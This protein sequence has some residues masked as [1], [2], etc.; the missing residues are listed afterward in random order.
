MVLC[1]NFSHSRIFLPE[2]KLSRQEAPHSVGVIFFGNA[3]LFRTSYCGVLALIV[4]SRRRFS[5]RSRSSHD[6]ETHTETH[7]STETHTQRRHT[8]NTHIQRRAH[9]HTLKD[10]HTY[11]QRHTDRDTH[12]I[13]GWRYP[14]EHG[15]LTTQSKFL[16]RQQS[17]FYLTHEPATACNFGGSVG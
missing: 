10:T 8:H 15:K 12:L 7:I 4:V 17:A 9:T 6:T 1:R 11:I 13:D 14:C 2:L 5:S 3:W 16:G